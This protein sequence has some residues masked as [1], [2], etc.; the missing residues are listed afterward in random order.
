MIQVRARRLLLTG[1]ILSAVAFTGAPAVAAGT[2]EGRVGPSAMSSATAE[3]DSQAAAR[4][5]SGGV[6][7]TPAAPKTSLADLEDEV[8]CPVCGTLLGLADAPQAQRQ[9]AMI[10]RM[11][12]R[13]ASKEEV[14]AALVDE[15]GS[16]VLALPEGSGFSLSAYLVPIVGFLLAAAGL[17]VAVVRWQRQP[18]AASESGPGEGSSPDGAAAS[19][20]SGTDRRLDE[21]LARYD[22]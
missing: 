3:G 14:K 16:E 6:P 4:G 19:G 20:G 1:A 22:L 8:M 2:A 11:V 18:A 10:N 7:A 15:F 13:G 9:K 5:T 12:D 21:D 17:A